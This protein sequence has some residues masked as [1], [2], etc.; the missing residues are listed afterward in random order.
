MFP[1]SAM[2]AIGQ[3]PP[4]IYAGDGA[5]FSVDVFDA[6]GDR[7]RIIR[8]AGEAPAIS[9]RALR[10]RRNERL[11]IAEADGRRA[12]VAYL[13]AAVPESRTYPAYQSLFVDVEGYLWAETFVDGWAI[14]DADGSW[15]GN[16]HLGGVSPLE[17]GSDYIL[18]VE[19]DRLDVQ[20]IVLLA[21]DR[22]VG[23][24]H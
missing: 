7:F 18:A 5:A 15:L 22:G 14:F 20:R 8:Q 9:R 19:T 3:T 11:R 23:R 21:L 13:L 10:A 1:T 6:S 17:I 24:R 2:L 16:L 12:D 4:R